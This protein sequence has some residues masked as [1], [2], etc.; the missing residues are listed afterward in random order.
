MKIVLRCDTK[1]RE[2]A[3][4]YGEPFPWDKMNG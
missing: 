4:S 3:A 1:D 2:P